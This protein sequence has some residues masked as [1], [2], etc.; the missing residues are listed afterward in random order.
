MSRIVEGYFTF[1]KVLIALLLAIMVV[2]VFGNVVLRYAFNSGITVSEEVSRWLFV[3]LTFLG[4]TVA[5]H[6][7]AHLGVDSIVKQLPNWGK[8]V[9]L[10][11]SQLLM[12]FV[13]WLLFTGSLEQTI[14]NWEVTAPASGLS[15]GLFYSSGIVFAVSTG[16]ILL[17][18][19]YRTVTGKISDAEL[20]MVKESEEQEQFEELQRELAERD[21]NAAAPR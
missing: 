12:L 5:M 4:A 14:I 16:L 17:N 18:D 19:L 3:W 2:L 10:V 15:T 8:R 9:C 11:I 13:T 6:E 1:L 20:I 7:H 21:R